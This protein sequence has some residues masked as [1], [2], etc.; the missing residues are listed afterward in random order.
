ML[1]VMAAMGMAMRAAMQAVGEA[2]VERTP[3]NAAA[4]WLVAAAEPQLLEV[5]AVAD[6]AVV[7]FPAAVAVA[8]LPVAVVADRAV[9]AVA[10]RAVVAAA[11]RAAAAAADRA[12]AAAV[13]AK[14]RSRENNERRSLQAPLLA[15]ETPSSEGSCYVIFRFF[16]TVVQ[17][18]LT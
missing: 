5:L 4:A 1:E 2:P 15:S 13:T 14:R 10:D 11:D 3:H 9:A 7:A 8:A 17:R 18:M 16:P 12:A 6:H